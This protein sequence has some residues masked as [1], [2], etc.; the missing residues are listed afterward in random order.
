[1]IFMIFPII[2]TTFVHCCNFVGAKLL[3]VTFVNLFMYSFLE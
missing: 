1:M 3:K 2:V